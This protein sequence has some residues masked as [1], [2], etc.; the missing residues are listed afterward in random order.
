MKTALTRF[1]GVLDSNRNGSHSAVYSVCSSHPFAIRAALTQALNDQTIAVIESTS[2]QVNQ[3]G[4]YTGMRPPDFVRLVKGIAGQVG[5]PADQVLFGGDH[6]GPF[7]WNRETADSVLPKSAEMVREY[8]ASGFSKIHL[9]VSMYLGDDARVPGMP[10][11]PEAVASRTAQLCS[12]AEEAW[13]QMP[14]GTDAPVYVVGNEVPVPGGTSSEQGELRPSSPD[15]VLQFVEC[16][17][18]EFRARRLEGA[19]ERVVAIV[20]QP[21]VEFG[22]NLIHEYNPAAAE[23]LVSLLPRLPRLVYE[24]HS[25]DYQLPESLARLVADHFGILKVGPALTFAFREAV[26]A[27]EEIEKELLPGTGKDARSNLFETVLQSMREDN[28]YWKSYYQADAADVELA[29]RYSFSDRIRYYW[30]A[31]AVMAAF[32]SLIGNLRAESIPLTLISQFMPTEYLKLR[33]G[34]ISDKPEELILSHIMETTKI[35]AA[36]CSAERR[37]ET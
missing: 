25:T 31:P 21:G 6:L 11:R 8:V 35:Y 1:K 14:E 32:D 30:S 7:P 29:L 26:I 12:A 23:G 13:K 16:M 36:A 22:D 37:P 27:L 9:D 24:A 19:W 28:R 33:E 4:G 20:V 5:F 15:D 10:L 18:H 3:L 17:E 2:N 34:R